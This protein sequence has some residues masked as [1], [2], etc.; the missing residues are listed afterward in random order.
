MGHLKP[1]LTWCDT[2]PGRGRR[3]LA[4]YL[5]VTLCDPGGVGAMGQPQI[6][7]GAEGY[8]SPLEKCGIAK[9]IRQ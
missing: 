1:G 3:I 7:G 8:V 5:S 6:G 4:D 2:I 9:L